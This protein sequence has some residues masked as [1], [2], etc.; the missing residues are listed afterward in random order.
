MMYITA[1][2]NR[3]MLIVLMLEKARNYK[4]PDTLRV[5]AHIMKICY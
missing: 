2:Q 5:S 4:I 3:D 1:L